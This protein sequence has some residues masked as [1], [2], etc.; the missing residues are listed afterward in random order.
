M[1]LMALVQGTWEVGHRPKLRTSEAF[2]AWM[3]AA[4]GFMQDS[5]AGDVARTLE[6]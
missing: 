3:T 1:G 4:T 2:K 6:R 5:S